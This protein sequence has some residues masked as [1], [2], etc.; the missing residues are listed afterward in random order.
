[1]LIRAF[2]GISIDAELRRAL[3]GLQQRLETNAGSP[4]VRWAPPDQLHLT[5]KFLGNV[6]VERLDEL[7]RA[8]DTACAGASAFSL[9]IRGVGCFPSV[10]RPHVIWAGIEGDVAA[11]EQL[12]ER[13]ERA[14][15]P[16]GSHSEDRK[17][18][19]HLTIGRVKSQSHARDRRRLSQAIRGSATESLGEWRVAQVDL[20]QS[21]LSPQGSLYTRWHSV[22]LAS[23]PF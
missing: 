11:L 16:F 12:Q 14:A 3:A 19:P 9:S 13:I 18:H 8:L 4:P 20:V 10:Q 6:P 17:F 22:A 15:S 21:Q 7:K 23:K 5:L 2:V 1:M